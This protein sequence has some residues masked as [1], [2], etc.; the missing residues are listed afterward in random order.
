M[1]FKLDDCMYYLTWHDYHSLVEGESHGILYYYVG[2]VEAEVF[3]NVTGASMVYKLKK[4]YW[5]KLLEPASV[6][7]QVTV[8][9]IV[10]NCINFTVG[11]FV[12]A[13]NNKYDFTIHI[14][15]VMLCLVFKNINIPY[16][17]HKCCC[18]KWPANMMQ[19]TITDGSIQ[20]L[21]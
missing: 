2:E 3:T 14:L 12:I 6:E 21:F 15:G 17:F 9:V 1:G 5:L 13:S 18:R 19:T 16:M 10:S 4:V 11:S 7:C 8:Q 20:R